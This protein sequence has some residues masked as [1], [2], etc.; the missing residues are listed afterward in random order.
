MQNFTGQAG[1]I[2]QEFG[3]DRNIKTPREVSC[4]NYISEGMNEWKGAE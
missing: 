3:Y 1:S 4:P 2:G